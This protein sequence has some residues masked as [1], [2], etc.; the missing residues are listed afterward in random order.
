MGINWTLD[1]C[2]RTEVIE[3]MREHG[4]S[5]FE[6]A[7]ILKYGSGDPLHTVAQLRFPHEISHGLIDT[8]LM[9]ETPRCGHVDRKSVV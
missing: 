4:R 7:P 2:G 8:N 9:R 6:A 1:I 3:H 5:G